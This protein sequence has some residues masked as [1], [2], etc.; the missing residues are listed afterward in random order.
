MNAEITA[1]VLLFQTRN[2]RKCKP[3]RA[4]VSHIRNGQACL[5]KNGIGKRGQIAFG[6][7]YA[8]AIAD[9]IECSERTIQ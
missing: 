9:F 8:Q 4:I 2:S 5:A 6:E 3:L 1:E 7:G